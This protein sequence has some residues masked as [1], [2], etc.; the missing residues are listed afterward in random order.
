MDYLNLRAL[1]VLA[2]GPPSDSVKLLLNASIQAIYHYLEGTEQEEIEDLVLAYP[3]LERLCEGPVTRPPP[4]PRLRP[5]TLE[6]VLTDF[7]RNCRLYRQKFPTYDRATKMNQRFPTNASTA[8]KFMLGI[9]TRGCTHLGAGRIIGSSVED[10]AIFVDWQQGSEAFDTEI[11]T[12]MVVSDLAIPDEDGLGCG[13]YPALLV[14]VEKW[15]KA[16]KK[17]IVK[18]NLFDYFRLKETGSPVKI[19]Y[20]PRR[21][22]LEVIC[23]LNIPGVELDEDIILEEI[24]AENVIRNRKI[25]EQECGQEPLEKVHVELFS[26]D[27][28]YDKLIEGLNFGNIGVYAVEKIKAEPFDPEKLEFLLDA[29]FN[30]WN[31]SIDAK[32]LLHLSNVVQRYEMGMPIVV[33]PLIKEKYEKW[34]EV[35]KKPRKIDL[36]YYYA[37]G[38]GV[39]SPI[40]TIPLARIAAEC[41]M[42]SV[43][44]VN[45]LYQILILN[46][47]GRVLIEKSG[48]IKTLAE[49]SDEYANHRR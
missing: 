17:I 7:I 27:K 14:L 38:G 45:N 4:T 10:A 48:T 28:N 35:F 18:L 25:Y 22:N 40:L 32:A 11:T 21:H 19:L 30:T 9:D 6:R 39:V 24:L 2:F 15:E 13:V 1:S 47:L 12:E 8:V 44:K 16:G 34:G 49:I 3:F 23:S 29:G 42:Y 46:Q 31:D 36:A 37:K 33:H 41:Y 5:H 20:K 26:D 43:E